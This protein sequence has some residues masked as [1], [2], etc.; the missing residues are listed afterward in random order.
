MPH[1]DYKIHSDPWWPTVTAL[2][3]TF[4]A[5]VALFLNITCCYFG[6]LFHASERQYDIIYETTC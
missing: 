3:H 4:L 2:M 6:L 5:F 1:T